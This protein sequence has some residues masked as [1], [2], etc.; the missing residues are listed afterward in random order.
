MLFRAGI[1]GGDNQKQII[2]EW[3]LTE[4]NFKLGKHYKICEILKY[5]T[6]TKI[7]EEIS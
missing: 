3:E 4:L 2:K 5:N 7:F 1:S 6:L